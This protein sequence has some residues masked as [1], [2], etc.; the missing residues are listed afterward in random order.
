MRLIVNHRD[1]PYPRETRVARV[2]D[3]TVLVLL[4]ALVAHSVRDDWA[5]DA[6]AALAAPRQGLPSRQ[7]VLTIQRDGRWTL[8]GQLVPSG[9]F[10]LE[11]GRAFAARPVKILFVAATPE[12]SLDEL[13]DVAAR[14]R[15]AGVTV[16]FLPAG[17]D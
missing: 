13:A 12:R 16:G 1:F 5:R 15:R 2:V 14:A 9:A 4:G 11:L 6:A 10:E 8:N 3:V 7:L 17:R